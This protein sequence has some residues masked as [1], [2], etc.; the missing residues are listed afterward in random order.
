MQKFS[1]SNEKGDGG[2]DHRRTQGPEDRHVTPRF[3]EKV[4]KDMGKIG[5]EGDGEDFEKRAP[6][7]KVNE[8]AY[9]GPREERCSQAVCEAA[10]KPAHF[11]HEY[12]GEKVEVG[13]VGKKNGQNN[14]SPTP[15][16][17]VFPG[18]AVD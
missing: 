6:L 16:V 14:S 12:S 9:E 8:K 15:P 7:R 17:L 13:E 5:C 18:Q 11:S 4:E 2:P 3:R 1:F 10:M